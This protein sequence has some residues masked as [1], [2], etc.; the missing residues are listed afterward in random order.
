MRENKTFLILRYV[1]F[2]TL[3][4]K[5]RCQYNKATCTAGHVVNYCIEKK[6]ISKPRVKYIEFQ[7]R[8]DIIIL[9]T[10]Q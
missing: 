4:I 10:F 8:L 6:R 1:Y 7:M 9:I 5:M 2:I 3:L